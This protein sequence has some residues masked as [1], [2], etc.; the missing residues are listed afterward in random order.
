MEAGGLNRIVIALAVSVIAAGSALAS[1]KSDIM[2]V[3]KEWN[4]PDDM[5]KPG[6]S[7]AN[8]AAVLDV[9]PP[10]E[11]HGPGACASFAKD[12]DASVRKLRIVGEVGTMG[13]PNRFD[14]AGDRAYLSVPVTYPYT[15]KGKLV[16]LTGTLAFALRRNTAGWRITACPADFRSTPAQ[17]DGYSAIVR[18]LAQRGIAVRIVVDERCNT[19]EDIKQFAEAKATRATER[20]WEW[21]ASY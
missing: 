13:E 2:A 19:L 6:A 11:W 14:V 18:A 21:V 1:D 7:C 10:Y 16:K 20:R 15:Q 8:D 17:L 5:M 3:L 9:L 4:D 12:Y